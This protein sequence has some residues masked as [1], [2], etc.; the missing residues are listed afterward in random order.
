MQIRKSTSNSSCVSRKSR[1]FENTIINHLRPHLSSYRLI[2]SPGS[3]GSFNLS[4]FRKTR[5]IKADLALYVAIY[6]II[7]ESEHKKI[8]K[9]KLTSHSHVNMAP[10]P[11]FNTIIITIAPTILPPTLISCR[12]G[13]SSKGTPA[14]GGVCV[15]RYCSSKFINWGDRYVKMIITTR[16]KPADKYSQPKES[17]ST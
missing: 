3:I 16:I 7:K 2:T 5:F 11:T 9:K 4:A 12:G 10:S 1:L 17:N 13:S 8:P 14:G 6:T 15:W